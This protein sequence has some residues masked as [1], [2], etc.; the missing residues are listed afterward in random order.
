MTEPPGRAIGAPPDS[1][2]ADRRRPLA[3]WSLAVIAVAALVELGL[4]LT[5]SYDPYGWLDWGHLTIHGA[6]DTG[7]APTWKP[8]PWLLTTPLA[9]TGGAAPTLWLIL[10][11]AGGLVALLLAYRLAT[12]LAGPLAGLSAVVAVLLCHSWPALMLTGNVEP[13]TAALVLGAL[14]RHLAGRRRTTFV[15]L[16]LASLMRPECGVL[17]VLYGAWLWR[18]APG[19]RGLEIACAL[20]LVLLWFLPPYVAT[21]HFFGSGDAVFNS[22]GASHNPFV[23]IYRGA[24]IVPWPVAIAAVIGLGFALRDP[25]LVSADQR[26]GF[27][28]GDPKLVSTDQRR[29]AIALAAIA[30]VWALSAA[31]M[32]VVGFPGVQRFMIPAAATGCVLAGAGIAWSISRLRAIL[33]ARR[34]PLV[35]V[36]SVLI[37]A[38]TA[39]YCGFRVNDAVQSIKAER[40]RSS[41]D[42][43]LRTAI[44]ET[45]GARR[46]FACGLPTADIEFQSTLGWDLHVAVGKVLFRPPRDVRLRRAIVLFADLP[47]YDRLGRGGRQLAHHGAWRVIALRG[48]PGC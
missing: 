20:L 33:R 40:A 8:L 38:A 22:G 18:R 36:G 9:L 6:L 30:A 28:L 3:L 21:G 13:G 26:L 32:A 14:D 39:W 47:R 27:A 44:A 25:K 45:G 46:I 35:V 42:R 23:V 48:G 7:G 2:R 31:A 34:S 43:S 1:S 17:L 5:P 11:C 19:V 37:V 24:R 10:T 41:L 4:R 15:L 16:W 29:T 12:G